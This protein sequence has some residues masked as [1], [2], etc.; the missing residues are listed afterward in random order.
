MFF[1]KVTSYKLQVTRKDKSKKLAT[2]HV[3]RAT[4]RGFTLIELMVTV[5]I[6]V[7]MTA[8]VVA[9]YGS[10]NDGTLLTSM[11]Y[12]VALALR[13]AQS[14][15][16]NVQ[17][18]NSTNQFSYPYGM[19]F[20]ISAPS[21]MILFAD[22][23]PSTPDGIY[24]PCTSGRSIP[25]DNAV[26]TYTLARGGLI[27]SICVFNTFPSATD[28]CPST[29][30]SPPSVPSVDITFQRPNPNAIIT[31]MPR[32]GSTQTW[33]YA[34]IQV[35]DAGKTSTRTIVI[36]ETGEIAVQNQ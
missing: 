29:S 31:A 18:Y 8:L 26:T 32:S 4:S 10:F 22:S 24:T 17:G 35:E 11:A 30:S 13:D 7:A 14:Y 34:A 28:P 19:D 23:N 9:K 2:Y 21:Q 12:D 16:S 33:A 25:C 15:G 36:G 6:F 1:K 20:N 27:S 5:A 3:P